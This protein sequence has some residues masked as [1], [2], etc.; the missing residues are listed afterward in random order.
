MPADLLTLRR[1]YA[2]LDMMS[3]TRV[4]KALPSRRYSDATCT[5]PLLATGRKSPQ[6]S[7]TSENNDPRTAIYNPNEALHGLAAHRCNRLANR[8]RQR[9]PTA[10]SGRIL[11]DTPST[12]LHVRLTQ[13]A[14][15]VPSRER[16]WPSPARDLGGDME[17]ISADDCR[18]RANFFSCGGIAAGL[19]ARIAREARRGG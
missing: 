9:K 14:K 16:A 18:R 19:G 3:I 11:V 8:S 12:I 10:L 2:S 6:F 7:E 13:R 15:Q 1:R 4:G 5:L 17:P